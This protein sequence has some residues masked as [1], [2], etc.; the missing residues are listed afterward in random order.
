ML[1]KPGWFVIKSPVK[2]K[3]LFQE[4]LYLPYSAYEPYVTYF[5]CVVVSRMYFTIFMQKEKR[6]TNETKKLG[7][8][9]L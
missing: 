3:V 9:Q 1:N 6:G 5:I 2:K 7:L 8:F 4:F